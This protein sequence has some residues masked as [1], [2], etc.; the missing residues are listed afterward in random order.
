MARG[1]DASALTTNLVGFCCAF[2]WSF[3]GNTYFVFRH[4]G[5][6]SSVFPRFAVLAIAT[7]GI[8]TAISMLGDRAQVSPLLSLACVVVV[9]PIVS[10]SGNSVWVYRRSVT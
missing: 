6:A 1:A 8:S 2:A 10:Y 5:S 3:L 7:F 4:P 9:I